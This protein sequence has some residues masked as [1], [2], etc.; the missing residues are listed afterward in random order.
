MVVLSVKRAFV[1]ILV[2]F[3]SFR[4]A[5]CIFDVNAPAA[6]GN[7][8]VLIRS[9]TPEIIINLL[10]ELSTSSQDQTGQSDI[11]RRDCVLFRLF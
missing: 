3:P 1:C 6:V 8:L 10:V 4:L 7:C 5:S 11:F 2:C 9:F